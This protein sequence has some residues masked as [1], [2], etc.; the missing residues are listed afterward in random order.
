MIVL[1][2]IFSK[3]GAYKPSENSE[4]HLHEC[5]HTRYLQDVDRIVIFYY[6]PTGKCYNEAVHRQAYC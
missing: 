1:V 6:S 5:E 2:D 3:C 4:A